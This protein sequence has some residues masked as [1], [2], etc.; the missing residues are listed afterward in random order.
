[1][2]SILSDDGYKVEALLFS[3]FLG[4]SSQGSTIKIVVQKIPKIVE[5]R[6][7][8]WSRFINESLE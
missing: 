5:S 3:S 8:N 4:S 6:I 2:S 1:M 7:M